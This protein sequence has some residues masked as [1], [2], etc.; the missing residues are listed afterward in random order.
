MRFLLFAIRVPFG[1]LI[2]DCRCYGQPFFIERCFVQKNCCDF[3]LKK[4]LAVMV[5][6]QA[7]PGWQMDLPIVTVK[8][9]NSSEMRAT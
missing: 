4:A 2:D 6:H 9:R 1:Q 7:R 3:I 8:I 5:Q